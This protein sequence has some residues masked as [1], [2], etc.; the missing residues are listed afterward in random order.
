MG[1]M[2]KIE[3]NRH[4]PF[5]SNKYPWGTRGLVLRG[6]RGIYSK[7]RENAYLAQ[8]S[9]FYTGRGMER[10][11]KFGPSQ[12]F[13]IFGTTMHLDA[14]RPLGN[15]R[16]GFEGVPGHL[17]EKNGKCLFGS[18]FNILDRARYGKRPEI[19]T[20]SDLLYFWYNDAP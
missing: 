14:R 5:F 10:D 2:L 6:F 15:A 3:P 9:T 4:F 8:F 11:P 13:F 16:A 12:I 19:R 18:I 7:K 20:V 17:F 1:K